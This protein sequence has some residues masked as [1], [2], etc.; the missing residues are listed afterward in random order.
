M[1]TAGRAPELIC[2]TDWLAEHI[3]DDDVVVL[4]CD[5]LDGYLRL[6]IPGA[7][8]SLS[9]YWKTDPRDDS[10]IYGMSDPEQFAQL[11]GRLG[12]TPET[13]VV[14]YDGSGS[15][16]AAR[17]WWTFD[18]FGHTNFKIL[19][20]GLDKWYAEGRPLSHENYRPQAVEYPTPAAPHDDSICRLDDIPG[21]IADDNHVF[22][23]VRSDGEW[24]GAN[25]RGTQRGGR[26][27]GRGAPGVVA[28]T[29]QSGADAEAAVGAASDAGRP[30][31]YAGEDGDHLLTGR[32]PCGARILAPATAGLQPVAELRRVLARVRERAGAP[33]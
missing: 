29:G 9:R 2:E 25:K 26:I 22:W 10:R 14:A 23:D 27:P 32:H 20:G 8:W 5:L 3:D 18:R 21:A 11:A 31:D 1:L 19:H 16:Y 33:D 24:T 30:G 13:T 7:V 4:D 6:H 17:T 28:H 12:I 15:L